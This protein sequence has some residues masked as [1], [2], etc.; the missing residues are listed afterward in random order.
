MDMAE[1]LGN[2]SSISP[3]HSKQNP[4]TPFT[5]NSGIFSHFS[6][7][8]Q[9]EENRFLIYS[10][11]FT[12]IPCLL[13]SVGKRQFKLRVIGKADDG[14]IVKDALVGGTVIWLTQL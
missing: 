10:V 2:F 1:D 14:A 4:R 5:R 11:L 7:S 3:V 9:K 13:V 6:V 12:R 8:A